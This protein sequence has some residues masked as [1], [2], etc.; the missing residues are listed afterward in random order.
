MVFIVVPAPGKPSVEAESRAVGEREFWVGGAAGEGAG[1]PGRGRGGDL[2]AGP[3]GASPTEGPCRLAAAACSR[4]RWNPL[5]GN[6]YR[7]GRHIFL[8]Y[9]TDYNSKGLQ[10]YTKPKI[11]TSNRKQTSLR[12]TRRDTARSS[13]YYVTLVFHLLVLQNDDNK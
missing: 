9:N 12:M 2:R 5:I 7:W 8:I 11:L 3:R 10:T 4:S 6:D 1:G 13:Q